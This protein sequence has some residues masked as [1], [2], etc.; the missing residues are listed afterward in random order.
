MTQKNL[1]LEIEKLQREVE[2]ARQEKAD[3]ELLLEMTTEHADA[4]ENELITAREVAEEA[5][6]AKSEFLANMSHEIRTPLNGIIGMTGLLLETTLSAEQ[7]DYINTI[8][9]S[10]EV[11]LT[12]INDILDFSKIEAGRLEL[13]N[14][15]FDLIE[16]VENCVELLATQAIPKNIN[17]ATIIDKNTPDTVLGD[18]TRIRQILVNLLSNAVKFTSQGEVVV[19]ISASPLPDGDHD[20]SSDT[21]RFT[22]YQIQMA[23]KDTGIGIPTNRLNRLFK[24]FSQVDTSTSRKYGGTGLGLAISQ[25]LTHLM[26]GQISVESEEGKG[27]TFYVTLKLEAQFDN[28]IY[29]YLYQTHSHLLARKVLIVTDNGTNRT[30]LEKQLQTWGMEPHCLNNMLEVFK[31]LNQGANWHIGIIETRTACALDNLNLLK[32]LRDSHNPPLPLIAFTYPCQSANSQQ[33]PSI[34]TTSLNKPLRWSKLY[35]TLTQ[36]FQPE[37]QPELSTSSQMSTLAISQEAETEIKF[38]KI[39]LAEDNIINQKVA[40]LILKKLGYDAEVASNGVEVLK[41]LRQHK[42]DIILM[43]VQMPEMDG[44]TATRHILKEYPSTN[45]RPW[46]VAMTANAMVGDREICLDAGMDDY[47]SKPIRKEELVSMFSRYLSKHN[48]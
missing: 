18:I 38:L 47:L 21:D 48:A 5:T 23:V 35:A 22:P 1:L 3:L 24:S 25:R 41:F 20:T 34:F 9:T 37:T 2:K 8:R 44:L 7:R 30:Q 42:Y 27:S 40:L 26:G 28:S 12:L 10:G 6:R 45:Q 43:D 11:L 29:G 46:I 13:E 4:V 31:A 36:I 33:S 19:W 32:K 16:C 15:P 39:L 14:R 17:L